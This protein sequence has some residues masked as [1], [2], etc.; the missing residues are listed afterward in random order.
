MQSS[1]LDIWNTALSAVHAKGRLATITDNKPERYQ[2]ET[3][4]DLVVRVVQEAAFWPSSKGI[5]TLEDQ[6][7]ITETSLTRGHFN[8]SYELP[9]SY[10]RPRHLMSYMPFEIAYGDDVGD[11]RLFTNDATPRL[12]YTFLQEDVTLW[13]PGQI[14]ATVYGL[15]AHIA[16]PITGRGELIQKNYNLANQYLIDAQATSINQ[17]DFSLDWVPEPLK[18]RGYGGPDVTSKF[19]YPFGGLFSND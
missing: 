12:V 19:L 17:E 5:F 16:G 11:V 10:L 13:T 18:A 2:C 6:Q 4:Y 8:Y 9:D 14:L 3:W 1:A 7:K 15:A